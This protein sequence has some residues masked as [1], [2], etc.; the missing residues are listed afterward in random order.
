MKK[1]LQAVVLILSS[2]SL[3]GNTAEVIKLPYTAGEQQNYEKPEQEYLSEIWQTKV[4]TNVSQPVMEVYRP[5]KGTENGTAIIIAPGG[6]LYAHSI[7]SEGR[8]AARWLNK[9]GITAFVL[10]YRLVPTEDEAVAQL[11]RESQTA[12]EPFIAKVRA[13]LR[14]SID[15]GLNAIG[16]VRRHA[17][18]YGVSQDRIG[19]MGF[20]AGGSVLLGVNNQYEAL[21]RP[22]FLVPVYPW[23]DIIEA[24][25]PKSDAPPMMI[26]CA[27][28][29]SVSFVKGA[30]ALY[31]T[32]FDAGKNVAI[33]MYSKGGHGFGMRQQGLPSDKWIE[34]VYDWLVAERLTR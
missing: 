19:F 1:L 22:D 24:Q 14:Y 15:D 17:Q 29:D 20:S 34:R 16:Y 9:K 30:N 8:D 6:G 32:Y 21:T 28:D 31:N 4:V 2:F 7:N 10:K 18:Q 12:P 11:S 33:H 3:M 25:S 26:I 13:T 5:S 27:S 23:T